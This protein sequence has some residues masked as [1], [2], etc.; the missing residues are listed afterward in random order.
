MVG[1]M[2]AVVDA[3]VG[4]APARACREL[5]RDLVATYR[6]DFAKYAG[7]MDRAVI[8]EVDFVLQA[9]TRVVPVELKAG[10]AGSMKSLHQFMFDR[11]L[12]LAL[13]LGTHGRGTRTFRTRQPLRQRAAA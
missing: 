12:P 8:D 4:G 10:S 3:D 1:G 7:R 11:Q 5:Q 2:P 6:A 13:R 9:G